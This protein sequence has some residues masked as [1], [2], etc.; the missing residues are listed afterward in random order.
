MLC[1]A[2]TFFR[3]AQLELKH[4]IKIYDLTLMIN[5]FKIVSRADFF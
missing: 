4:S 2:W 3:Y 5:A 1:Y